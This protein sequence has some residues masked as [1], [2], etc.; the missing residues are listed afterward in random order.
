MKKYKLISILLLITTLNSTLVYGHSGRTDYRGGHYNHST[1]QYHYHNGGSANPVK[2][3][4]SQPTVSQPT[5]IPKIYTA[6]LYKQQIIIN[7][8]TID[9]ITNEKLEYPILTYNDTVYLPLTGAMLNQIGIKGKFESGKLEL[10]TIDTYDTTVENSKSYF[11]HNDYSSLKKPNYKIVINGNL[12]DNTKETN[13]ILNYKDITYLPLTYENIVDRLNLNFNIDVD[14]INISNINVTPEQLKLNNL[15]IEYV[16]NNDYEN[17]KLILEKGANPNTT[18]E[19]DKII[20]PVISITSNVEI[21][22]ILLENNASL[23]KKV[24]IKD[25][26]EYH[27]LPIVYKLLMD[28]FDTIEMYLKYDYDKNTVIF[29]GQTLVN[30]ITTLRN[31]SNDLK[32]IDFYNKVISTLNNKK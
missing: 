9:S 7:N 30:Y 22:E 3:A 4:Y 27:I 8:K 5:Q 11:T 23:R 10:T 31:D 1:G 2:P 13:P 15:L 25:E 20:F 32:K 18:V 26:T 16:M 28:D 19:I 21:A 14:E 29:T 6:T 12:I 17:V 24:V